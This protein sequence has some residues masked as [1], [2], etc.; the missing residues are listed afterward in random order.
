MIDLMVGETGFEPATSCSQSSIEPRVSAGSSVNFCD[1]GPSDSNGLL[2]ACKPDGW[3]YIVRAGN[4]NAAKIGWSG[5]LPDRLRTLQCAHVHPLR[6]LASFP[7]A[8]GDEVRLHHQFRS[9]RMRGEWF[10]LGDDLRRFIAS[11]GGVRM[12]QRDMV[13]AT[14]EPSESDVLS[15]LVA[16]DRAYPPVAHA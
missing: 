13:R 16:V 9:L 6:L 5:S 10:R 11:V 8:R 15:A 3:I 7:G 2:G 1:S 14:P 12:V 4:Q